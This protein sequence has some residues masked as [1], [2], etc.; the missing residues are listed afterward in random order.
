MP[1]LS[2][3]ADP[4]GKLLVSFYKEG[5]KTDWQFV[6]IVAI[7]TLFDLLQTVRSA[8]RSFVCRRIDRIE[9]IDIK[10]NKYYGRGKR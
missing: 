7:G 1:M 3:K 10:N 9:I 6:T 4:E 8:G 5:K 2:L